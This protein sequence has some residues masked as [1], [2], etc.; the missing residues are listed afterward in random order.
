MSIPKYSHQSISSRSGHEALKLG[1]W[2]HGDQNPKVVG[3]NP[4]LVRVFLCPRMGTVSISG[5]SPVQNLSGKKMIKDMTL[6]LTT[7]ENK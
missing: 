1:Q 3:S 5:T 7:S 2:G 4:T 6:I